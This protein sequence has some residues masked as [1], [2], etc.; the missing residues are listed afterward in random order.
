MHPVL[1][2]SSNGTVSVHGLNRSKPAWAPAAV[3]WLEG[4][5]LPEAAS[6]LGR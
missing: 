1:S 6:E 4:R 5:Y 2:P 3:V